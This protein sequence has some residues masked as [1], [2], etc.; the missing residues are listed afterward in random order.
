MLS[1]PLLTVVRLT[2]D[3]VAFIGIVVSKVPVTESLCFFWGEW[4]C[5]VRCRIIPWGLLVINAL[6]GGEWGTMN[7]FVPQVIYSQPK[8]TSTFLFF[9]W[10]VG[11]MTE[12]GCNKM[13]ILFGPIDLTHIY[14]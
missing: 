14:D 9:F 4:L 3:E 2:L 7:P 10:A 11:W 12:F 6:N 8:W 13:R 5:V 1:F